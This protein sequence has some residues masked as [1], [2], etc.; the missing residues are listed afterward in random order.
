[1]EERLQW[2]GKGRTI[3][4]CP[5]ADHMVDIHK[6]DEVECPLC[7]VHALVIFIRITKLLAITDIHTLYLRTYLDNP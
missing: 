1:M 7:G 4:G 6:W 2:K 3:R 5:D